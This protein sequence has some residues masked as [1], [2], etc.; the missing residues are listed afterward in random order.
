MRIDS[1]LLSH[2]V[3]RNDTSGIPS[4]LTGHALGAPVGRVG[5]VSENGTTACLTSSANGAGSSSLIMSMRQFQGKSG[6]MG[7]RGFFGFCRG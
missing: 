3:C 5:I 1:D 7:C 6:N 2:T 4:S